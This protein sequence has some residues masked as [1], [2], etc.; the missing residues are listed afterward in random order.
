V[1]TTDVITS[2]KQELSAIKK[3]I[4]TLKRRNLLK[5]MEHY[6]SDIKLA[7]Y[8]R[9]TI[10]NSPITALGVSW[11]IDEKSRDNMRSAIEAAE[12]NA[13]PADTTIGW[14]LADDTVRQTTTA[15]LMQV[16]NAYAYRMQSVYEAYTTWLEGD[17]ETAFEYT[18][19]Q[20]GGE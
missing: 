3:E 15:D 5:D 4:Y 11:D 16:L 14:I 2:I 19:E 17:M 10:I 12:R 20:E 9:D 8:K 1:E 13:L 18:E 6:G 7:K